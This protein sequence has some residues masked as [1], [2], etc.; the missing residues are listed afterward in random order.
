MNCSFLGYYGKIYCEDSEGRM[1]LNTLFSSGFGEYD[2]MKKHISTIILILIF[3]V[4][5]L[6]LLYPI[7]SDWWNSKV[8]TKAIAAYEENI[9]EMNEADYEA[10]F[11]KADA[12]N[13]SLREISMPLLNYE[14]AAGYE[15]ILNVMGNG[16]IGYVTIDKINVK[17]PIYHGTSDNILNVAVGNLRGSSLPVGGIGTHSVLSAHRGLPSAKLFSDL[18]KL[19]ER[20]TFTI[21]VLNRLLTYE[22]D[23]ISI[24]EPDKI[25]ELYI[26]ED[27]DY[28]TLMTCTPYGIN[29][30]R[31]L[32]RAHRIENEEGAV[33]LT[34]DAYELDSLILVP[35]VAAPLLLILFV[36]ILIKYRK[37][38]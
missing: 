23:H 14:Q 12:Y 10:E 35:V 11:A 6:V 2:L 17:L 21:T 28:C 16:M 15:D 38:R 27:K 5:L 29:T 3:F 7:V 22:V 26:E 20:D 4:G 9:S 30:H 36:F 18:D 8:Q 33:V 1:P 25:E 37:K 24:V 32:V 31:L 34:N 13:A 19:K